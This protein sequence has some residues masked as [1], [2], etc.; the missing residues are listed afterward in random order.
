MISKNPAGQYP[1]IDKSAYVD[2]SARIIGNVK[3][4]K[5][6]FIGPLAVIRADEPD[7]SIEI[8][9]DCNVQDH[10]I[11]HAF[12]GAKVSVG[13]SSSLSHGSIVH[14]PCVIGKGCF[15]GFGAVVVNAILGDNVATRHLTVIENKTVKG[16]VQMSELA[17]RVV[18]A[19]R[20]LVRGYK[21][22]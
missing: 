17:K 18:V 4:G 2:K 1:N 9:D 5:N 16:K 12:T 13:A 10:V 8:G 11:V 3:V 19:N 20:L 14:G 15:V 7:S 6:V 21:K 22:L